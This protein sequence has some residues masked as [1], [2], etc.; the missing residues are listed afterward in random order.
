M[1]RP[2]FDPRYPIKPDKAVHACYL[3]AQEIRRN[4][5]PFSSATKRV[6]SQ[7][8][9]HYKQTNKQTNMTWV[10]HTF[11]LK[12]QEAEAGVSSEFGASL[13]CIVSVR[14]VKATQYQIK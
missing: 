8:R 2:G 12:I 7:P 5:R 6:Q 1:Q 10:M 13:I 11:N 14:T 4:S 3:R 9:I